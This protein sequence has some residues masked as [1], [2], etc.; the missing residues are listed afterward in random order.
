MLRSHNAFVL[1]I[2]CVVCRWVV[3]LLPFFFFTPL[4]TFTFTA[5]HTFPPPLSTPPHPT[6]LH[7]TSPHLTPFHTPTPPHLTSPHPTP[8]QVT[9]FLCSDIHKNFSAYRA[10]FH[11]PA[12]LSQGVGNMWYSFDYGSPPA[13]ALF[14]SCRTHSLAFLC[15]S[16]LSFFFSF[17]SLLSF[18][19]VIVQFLFN[20]CSNSL[21]PAKMFSFFVVCRC[22]AQHWICVLALLLSLSFFP[23]SFWFL[24]L[25]HPY[26]VMVPRCGSEKQKND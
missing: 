2:F 5:P 6:P 17:I 23:L 15:F 11:M 19:L 16:F 4:L 3:F 18:C 26:L 25:S 22:R 12:S 13:A 14:L 1:S 8:I 7:L 24:R 20:F 9:P 10:R 21:Y